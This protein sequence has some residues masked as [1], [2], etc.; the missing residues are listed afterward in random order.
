MTK[1]ERVLRALAHEPVDKIPSGFWFHFSPDEDTGMQIVEE[2][3]KLYRETGMDMI[4]VMCDGFFCYPNEWIQ[5]VK[6]PEDWYGMKPLGKEHAYIQNQVK[7]AKN[8][9]N[10]VEGECCV[11]YNVFC[12][13]SL[14]RFGT[15]EE[16]LMKHI[17]QNPEA[18]K[19]AFDVIAQDCKTLAELVITEAGCD[20]IY[21]CVQ[22]AEE[23]RFTYEEYRSLVTPAELSVLEHAN[24]FSDNNILHCCGWA[25]DKNR[26][27]VWKDYP[28]KAVNWAIYI[29]K[30]TLKQGRRF[31]A[32]SCVLGGFDNR[33]NGVLYS[34]SRKEIEDFLEDLVISTGSVGLIIGAD[35]TLPSDIEVERLKWVVEKLDELA[36]R[37]E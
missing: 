15:S 1:K 3:L 8:V 31:F 7:R 24:K 29:E 25:G 22:N 32:G 13:M 2:H 30:L 33:K 14:M 36:V 28:A 26:I 21:Y 10:G 16:L 20:G 18:V 23:D 37:S 35:C 12:P 6:E 34:G 4:K 17:R 5:K 19:Y 9:V 11:F 27:E